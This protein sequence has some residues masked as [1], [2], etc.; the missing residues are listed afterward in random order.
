M[1][2]ERS[3]VGHSAALGN[4]P[5]VMD[6]DEAVEHAHEMAWSRDL[7]DQLAAYP[8][9]YVAL[10]GGAIVAHAR[11]FIALMAETKRLGI[12]NPYVVAVPPPGAQAL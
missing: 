4:M 3:G 2:A 1:A 9:E 12:A 5:R 8:N 10:D 6:K 7:A 11:S